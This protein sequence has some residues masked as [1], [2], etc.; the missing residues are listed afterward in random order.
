MTLAAGGGRLHLRRA[1]VGAV[2]SFPDFCRPTTPSRASRS[3]SICWHYY[4]PLSSE[5]VAEL[6]APRLSTA[7]ALPVFAEGVDH[8]RLNGT[9]IIRVHAW[10]VKQQVLSSSVELLTRTSTAR[11]EG[12]ASRYRRS[13]HL[14]AQVP[15]YWSVSRT[16]S[17]H[18]EQQPNN[19]GSALGCVFSHGDFL[20]QRCRAAAAAF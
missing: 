1:A 13:R 7:D 14:M 3:Y 4:A 2:T 10:L 16:Q 5:R 12:S 20:G 6:P 17:Q 11:S 8:A 15:R 18:T 19:F 9:T